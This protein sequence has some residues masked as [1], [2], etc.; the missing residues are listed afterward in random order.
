MTFDPKWHPGVTLFC[1]VTYIL[2]NRI[3]PK[4]NDSEMFDCHSWGQ[5]SVPKKMIRISDT[6]F[7]Q[8]LINDT[9]L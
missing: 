3:I 4:V 6:F 5:N 2:N 1:V 8:I 9:S 7:K